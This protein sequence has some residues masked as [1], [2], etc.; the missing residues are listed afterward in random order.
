MKEFDIED[1]FIGELLVTNECRTLNFFGKWISQ[2]WEEKE[3]II[4]ELKINLFVSQAII[5]FD[6]PTTEKCIMSRIADSVI[7]IGNFYEL[8]LSLDNHGQT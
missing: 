7:I 4:E 8:L 2:G 3:K 5:A 1:L 6:L